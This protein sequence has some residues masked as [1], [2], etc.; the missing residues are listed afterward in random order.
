MI[1]L[2]ALRSSQEWTIYIDIQGVLF[3]NIFEMLYF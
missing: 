1:E 3:Q 2:E